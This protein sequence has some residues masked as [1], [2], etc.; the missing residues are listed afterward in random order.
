MA[1]AALGLACKAP[2]ELG[3]MWSTGL[4]AGSRYRARVDDELATELRDA[5]PD[6]NG[7]FLNT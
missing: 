7:S 2:N 3:T 1:M 4:Q 5:A 6:G